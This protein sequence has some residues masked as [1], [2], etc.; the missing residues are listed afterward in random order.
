MDNKY[1]HVYPGF[2]ENWDEDEEYSLKMDEFSRGKH[3]KEQS[4]GR[5]G[6][7]V[8]AADRLEVAARLAE[9]RFPERV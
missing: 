4:S 2:I 7:A 1:P 5:G 8:N 6:A 9:A 3:E